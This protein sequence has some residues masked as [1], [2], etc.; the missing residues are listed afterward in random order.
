MKKMMM[1]AAG[2]GAVL[3]M[4]GCAP[5]APVELAAEPSPT[6]IVETVLTLDGL[7]PGMYDGTVD[8]AVAQAAGKSDT[9]WCQVTVTT[10][11]GD[12]MMDKSMYEDVWFRAFDGA[13]VTLEGN[14]PSVDQIERTAA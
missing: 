8:A 12:V 7:K 14:C 4:A 3:L 13:I 1:C 11:D 5:A 2:A 9:D 10:D 6:P